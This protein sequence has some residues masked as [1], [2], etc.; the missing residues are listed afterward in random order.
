MFEID[1]STEFGKRVIQRLNHEE[2]IWLTTVQPSGM[3]QPNPVWFLWENSTFLIY[4]QPGSYKLRNLQNN[5]R[6]S[7]HFNCD[8]AGGDVI[9]FTGEAS[10]DSDTPPAD[11]HPAYLSKYGQGITGIGMTPE[12]FTGSYSV[13]IRVKPAKVRG[14]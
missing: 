6:V 7:I 3:P 13:P 5:A 2:V 14:F 12:S 8:E 10:I 4:T 9:V 1:D 11:R